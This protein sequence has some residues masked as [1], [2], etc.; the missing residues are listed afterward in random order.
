LAKPREP[1]DGKTMK[2][3]TLDQLL[4]IR[5]FV[6]AQDFAKSRAF[7]EKLGFRCTFADKDVCMMKLGG[8]SFILQNF[9]VKE[10]ADN[11]MLQLLVRDVEPWWT[12]HVDADALVAEFAVRPPIP[13]ALQPWGMIVGF[14]ID[15]SGVLLHV[16][17]A[18]F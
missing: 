18:P 9:Y 5:P 17:E 11:F 1:D 12:D 10:L 8:C 13:P 7:Y 14:L 15:P 6:P 16:A 2:G 4:A 3:K